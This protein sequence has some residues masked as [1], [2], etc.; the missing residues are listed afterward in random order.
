M[1]RENVQRV[2]RLFTQMD[3]D[4]G[5]PLADPVYSWEGFLKAVA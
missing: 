3:W 4:E 1:M 5:F 2:I